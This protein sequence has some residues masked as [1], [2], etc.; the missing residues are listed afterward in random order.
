MKT[1]PVALVGSGSRPAGVRPDQS[2]EKWEWTWVSRRG[3]AIRQPANPPAGASPEPVLSKRSSRAQ[4]STDGFPSAWRPDYSS[5]IRATIDKAPAA[6][7]QCRHMRVLVV[8]DRRETAAFI[9]KAL[10]AE[11]FAVDALND[12]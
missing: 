9:R 11:G 1:S 6:A 5:V 2:L 4:T 7:K 8:E 3:I 12:G 10:Q